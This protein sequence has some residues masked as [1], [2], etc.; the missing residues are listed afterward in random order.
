MTANYFCRDLWLHL[1]PLLRFR[2]A[3]TLAGSGTHNLKKTKRRSGKRTV[4]FE[5]P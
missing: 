3:A 1:K 2:K 4:F 5:M